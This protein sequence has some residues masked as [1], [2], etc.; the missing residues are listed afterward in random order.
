MNENS[1]P[2]LAITRF[3]IGS[4]PKNNPPKLMRKKILPLL[5]GTLFLS[6]SHANDIEPGKEYYSVLKAQIPSFWMAIFKWTGIPV[7]ADPNSRLPSIQAPATLAEFGLVRRI[8]GGRP[9]RA[10]DQTSFVQITCN[11]N[12]FGFV[13]TDDYH[14]NSAN[15]AWNGDSVQLIAGADRAAQWHFT[16][17]TGWHRE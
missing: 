2:H 7:L 3:V 15:S 16:V 9:G 10:D 14:E 8:N 13:V 17:R 1:L 6:L 4:L 11:D 5:I 12:V